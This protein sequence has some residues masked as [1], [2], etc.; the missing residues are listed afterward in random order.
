MVSVNTLDKDIP[1]LKLI[2]CQNIKVSNC[3]QTDKIDLFVSEDDKCSG[4]YIVNNVLPG[5]VSLHNNKGKNIV[6]IN[7]AIRYV[8]KP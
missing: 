4:I 8:T 6:T 1:F 2:N 7:N 3:Y 5:T